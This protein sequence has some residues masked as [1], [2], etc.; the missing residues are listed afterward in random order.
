[1]DLWR[2]Y[3]ICILYVFNVHPLSG[4]NAGWWG[5]WQNTGSSAPAVI[6]IMV[7]RAGPPEGGPVPPAGSSN[8]VRVTTSNSRSV[9]LSQGVLMNRKYALGMY[10]AYFICMK[11]TLKIFI[12][13]SCYAFYV[14]FSRICYAVSPRKKALATPVS[15]E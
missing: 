3:L 5:R 10:S 9:N 13:N 2:E 14:M 4:V 12:M 8:P 1:M 7:T 6:P 15:V 11:N